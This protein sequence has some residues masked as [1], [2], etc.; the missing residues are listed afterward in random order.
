MYSPPLR[1]EPWSPDT[2]SQ[3]ATHELGWPVIN[4]TKKVFIS[5][6]SSFQDQLFKVLDCEAKNAAKKTIFFKVGHYFT[7]RLGNL[8]KMLQITLST[9]SLVF[10][11]YQ[12]DSIIFLKGNFL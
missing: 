7:H 4:K 12:G 11:S 10:P 2:E 6:R 8:K 9:W 1:F 3:C 5:K